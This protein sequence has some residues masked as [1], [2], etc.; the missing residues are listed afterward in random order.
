MLTMQMLKKMGQP[1][2]INADDRKITYK[3]PMAKTTVSASLLEVGI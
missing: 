1:V 2:S 3:K